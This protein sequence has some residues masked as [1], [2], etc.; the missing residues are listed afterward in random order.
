MLTIKDLKEF[1]EVDFELFPP[2]P[3]PPKKVLDNCSLIEPFIFQESYVSVRQQLHFLFGIYFFK[4]CTFV[5]ST[6]RLD[7]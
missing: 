4:Y 6:E 1:Y 2:P 7:K 5:V 3:H